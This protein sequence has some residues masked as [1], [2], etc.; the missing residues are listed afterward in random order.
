MDQ[1]KI[2]RFIQTLRKEKGLTQEQ[3]AEQFMVARRTV[4][5]WE[6]GSNLPDIALLAQM[7]DF[8]QVDLRELLDGERK[9]Q[10][11]DPELKETVD[12][13]AQYSDAKQKRITRIV[14]L[15]F[16]VGILG[17]FAN[18]ALHFMELGDT[19][20][21]GFCKG[22]TFGLALAAMIMGIL[23]TRGAL[24]KVQ[25]CKKGLLCGK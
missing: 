1:M 5:R 7:A 2:G 21:V 13:V 22:G 11:M 17:L 18:G 15:Y 10:K 4:S 9:Q 3:L 12:K 8:F 19:F 23:Y 6:T 20:W 25:A 14:R 16:I 24:A